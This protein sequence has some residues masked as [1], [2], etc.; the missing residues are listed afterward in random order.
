ME[1]KELERVYDK[2]SKDYLF[3]R[4]AGRGTS[5][6]QNREIEQPMMFKLV[7]G[8]LSNKSLLD[9]GCGPGIHI[10]EYVSRGAKCTGIDLS[11]EMIKLAKDYCPHANFEVGN[12]YSLGFDGESFDIVTSSFVLDHVRELSKAVNGIKR[13]LKS[14]G[15][16]IFSIPHPITYMFRDSKRSVFTPSNSYFD[17]G[18]VYYNIAKS[19]LKFPAFPRILQEY[20]QEFLKEGFTLV[21]FVENIPKEEWASIDEMSMKIPYLAFFVWKKF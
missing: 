5:G 14:Q 13:V 1:E 11:S 4:T 17:N 2:V 8:D 21:D 10:K 6:F 15:L 9:I 12:I 18:V 3:S 19:G 7:P 16:F 20:F